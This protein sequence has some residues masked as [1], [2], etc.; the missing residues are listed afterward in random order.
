M[1]KYERLEM[2]IDM[3]EEKDVVVMSFD[4]SDRDPSELPTIPIG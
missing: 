1:K 4:D 2:I 3:F